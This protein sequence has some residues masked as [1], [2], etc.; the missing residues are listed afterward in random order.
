MKQRGMD[1]QAYRD[2]KQQFVTG[3]E[4]TSKAELLLLVLPLPLGA[5]SGPYAIMRTLQLSRRPHQSARVYLLSHRS[6]AL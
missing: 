1:W 2:A 4:G 5:A 3:H 6:A